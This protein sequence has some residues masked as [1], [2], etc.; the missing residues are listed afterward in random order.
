MLV[1]VILHFPLYLREK[2]NKMQ[3]IIKEKDLTVMRELPDDC[4]CVD[5]ML[6]AYDIIGRCFGQNAVIKAHE[7]IDP[8]TMDIK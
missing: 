4:S 5:A 8:D 6:A 2:D 3:I 7:I 1:L